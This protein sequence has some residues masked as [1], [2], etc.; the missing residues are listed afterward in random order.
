MKRTVGSLVLQ[1]L[2]PAGYFLGYS[3]FS[4]LDGGYDSLFELLQAGLGWLLCFSLQEL[5]GAI[6]FKRILLFYFA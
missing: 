1:S 2:L 4:A 6:S 3:Y 5:C